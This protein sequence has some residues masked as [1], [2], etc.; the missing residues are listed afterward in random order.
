MALSEHPAIFGHPA[1]LAAELARGVARMLAERGIS[2]L[3]EMSL[4]S[5]RR[6]DVMG[7]GRDGRVTVVEIKS[8]IAD[9]RADRKWPEYLDYC[10]F[11]YFAVPED[12]PT[13]I[14][15]AEPGLIVADRFDGVV[16]RPAPEQPMHASRRR[17]VTLRFA[18][19]AADRLL[20]IGEA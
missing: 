6:V 8:S 15:P 4:R 3:T 18:R 20:R 11:F 10:D 1:G 16:L 13:E 12:F 17:N 5:G 19:A 2:T 7:L 14:L 9:F